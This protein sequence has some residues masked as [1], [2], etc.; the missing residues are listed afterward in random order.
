MK[1]CMFFSLLFVSVMNV[2]ASQTPIWV[3]QEAKVADDTTKFLNTLQGKISENNS[4]SK[5]TDKN[6]K[7]CLAVS[8]GA[9]ICCFVGLSQCPTSTVAVTAA[10]AIAATC[11]F[12]QPK[13]TKNQ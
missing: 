10:S 6:C 8:A 11:I 2:N 12:S 1:K 13:A 4:D 3:K 5:K 7:E 9:T